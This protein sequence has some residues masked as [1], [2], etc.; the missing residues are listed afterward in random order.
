MKHPL[1][2]ATLCAVS[3][4]FTHSVGAKTVW[5]N[6][7]DDGSAFT[8]HIMYLVTDGDSASAPGSLIDVFI[9]NTDDGT[10]I[11][12]ADLLTNPSLAFAGYYD[13]YASS[14]IFGSDPAVIQAPES[15]TEITYNN[16]L[17][18]MF[19]DN[20]HVGQVNMECDYLDNL[21]TML[22]AVS[23]P[24][25]GPLNINDQHFTYLGIVNDE[26]FS[27]VAS[28]A[29]NPVPIPAAAWL[30]SSGLLGL[31]GIARRKKAA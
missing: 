21:C 16:L 8:T 26:F 30:F 12:P 18:T 29:V 28:D 23:V 25:R 13:L 9:D 19:Q 27:A 3:T 20:I 4:F 2:L 10:T 5:A 22:D 14:I 6:E 24:D 31:I 1:I 7:Y 17:V 11:N 15:P